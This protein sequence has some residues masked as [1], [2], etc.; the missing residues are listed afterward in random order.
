[1]QSLDGFGCDA[2][3]AAVGAAGA[4]LH[5]L[6][7]ELRRSLGHI[8]RLA[9]YRNSQFMVVDAATQ[10]NLELVQAR[11]GGRDTRCSARSTAPSRRWARG[12]CA[13]GFCIRSASSRR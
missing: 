13:T 3:P 8:T 4:I 7:T 10:A 11:G 2:M 9:V 5:Y 1:M 6:K 12:S